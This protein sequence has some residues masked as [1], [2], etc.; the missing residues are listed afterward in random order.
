MGEAECSPDIIHA[1]GP[2]QIEPESPS[3][4]LPLIRYI[5]HTMDTPPTLLPALV[6][7]GQK[8]PVHAFGEDVVFHLTGEQT[9]GTFTQWVETTPPGAGPPPHW[10]TM[11]DE[12]FY[13]LEGRASFLMDGEWHEAGIGAAAFMPKNS[14]HAFKNIGDGPLR[15]LITTAPSGFETFFTRCA[16][17]FANPA[18]PDMPRIILESAVEKRMK[19]SKKGQET[20]DMVG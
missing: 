19:R 10:H 18:G 15:M 12:S 1:Y 8:H 4:K 16:A 9:G 17:E 13:V 3:S 7:A 11:E 20:A 5:P 14:V 6:A 2:L